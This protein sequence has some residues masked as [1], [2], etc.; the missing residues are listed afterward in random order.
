MP[1]VFIE[2][3]DG[4]SATVFGIMLP[5]IAADL[6]RRTGFLNLAIG[7]AGAGGEHRRHA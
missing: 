1:L 4:V 3:L 6:T 5:L 2:L 7:F